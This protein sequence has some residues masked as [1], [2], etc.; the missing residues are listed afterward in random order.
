MVKTKL[1]LIFN[2]AV[3]ALFT[4]GCAEINAQI[5]SGQATAVM[6]TVNTPLTP[7]VTTAISDTGPLPTAGGSITLNSTGASVPGVVSAGSSSVST[8]GSVGTAQ[9]TASVNTI[10]IGVLSNTITATAVSSTTQATCPGALASGS[11]TIAGLTLNGNPITV[12]GAPNQTIAIFLLGNQIGTL[13]I[14]EQITSTGS[15]TVNA[16]HL[17]VTD[18]GDLTTI[19]VFIGSS[20]SD[21]RCAVVPPLNLFSGRGTGIRLR[22]QAIVGTD[23][24][25]LISDTGFLPTSGSAPITTSTAGAGL[26]PL[27]TTGVVTAST[28]GG[29]LAG[30]LN[31]SNSSA[32][33]NNLGVNALNVVTIAASVLSSTTQCTCSAGAGS[34]SGTSGITSLVVTVSGIPFPITITGVP[35][36]VVALPLGLGTLVI[37]ERF[38]A[39]PSDLT[40]NALH[41][42]L[43]VAGLAAT[44]LIVSSAHSDINCA[45]PPSSGVVTVGGRV[46][47]LDGSGIP[48]ALVRLTAQSGESRIAYT[49]S[50]GYYLFHDVASEESYFVEV[51]K[52]GYRFS[53]RIIVPLDDMDDVDFVAQGNVDRKSK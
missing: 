34:C 12:T 30:N 24:T 42:T 31:Q 40:V 49:S 27:L 47:T 53:P 16:L 36:Q 9:S 8:S 51:S 41:V 35:N 13:V 1:Q 46:T 25:T 29:V 48:Q 33:V 50:L 32:Q 14:N 19:N 10:N 52:K 21:I 5:Y 7:V 23:I 39:G 26:A 6:S 4:I 37:N 15:I 2:L 18:P 22:Q 17:S 38:S 43:N 11:S 3:L 44:D 28:S 45:I 20:H